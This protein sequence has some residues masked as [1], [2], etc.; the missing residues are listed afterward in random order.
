MNLNETLIHMFPALKGREMDLEDMDLPVSI[1]NSLKRGG[2]HTLAQLLE[3]SSEELSDYF[4]NRKDASC[5]VV[6]DKLER[7]VAGDIE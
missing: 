5:A 2:I 1:Y 3:L 6:Q 7:L 4:W